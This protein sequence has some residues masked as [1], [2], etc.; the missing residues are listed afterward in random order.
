MAQLIQT[1]NSLIETPF[2]SVTFGGVEFGVTA[3]KNSRTRARDILYVTSLSVKR[4]A[5]G[6]VN[7]YS[8][9]LEYPIIPGAD[10]N[11]IDYIISSD[12]SRT[13]V[14][15]YGDF[16]QPSF[17]YKKEKAIITK[18]SPSFSLS[19]NKLTYSIEATSSVAILYS[20]KRPYPAVTDKPSTIIMDQLYKETDN[21]LL[22][23]FSGMRDETIV[24]QKNLIAVSDRQ[25][26]IMAKQDISPLEY[27]KFLVSIMRNNLN[28]SFYTLVIHDIFDSME[29]P[30]F[31]VIESNS[32]PT[33]DILEIDVGYPGAVPIFDFS[34]SEATSYALITPLQEKYDSNRVINI[35]PTGTANTTSVPSL[36]VLH[37]VVSEE[38]ASWWKNMTSFPIEATL[39][40]RGLIIPSLLCQN[41]RINVL[42]Y[43]RP[44]TYS[45]VYM[46]TGQA[47]TISAGGFRTSLSMVR[48]AGDV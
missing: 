35:N 14:F 32:R 20:L 34:V 27:I 7:Q 23:L 3:N 38:R 40:T 10:P 47:D 12:P 44:H 11:Y 30:Y 33:Q 17:S 2:V 18:I 28:K 24:R 31:E 41:I 39:S 42:F 5:S 1:F 16:S 46:V 9:T 15:T 26:T 8:L 4:F 25:T 37:G 29:G 36:A 13:I 48:V 43:G 22:E 19:G 6:M 45:G 21:G